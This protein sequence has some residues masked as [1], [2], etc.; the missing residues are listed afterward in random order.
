MLLKNPQVLD[1]V[2]VYIFSLF[3]SI[4]IFLLWDTIRD[5]YG[6]HMGHLFFGFSE[7]RFTTV[8]EVMGHHTG[9]LIIRFITIKTHPFRVR[10]VFSPFLFPTTV[11]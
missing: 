7:I 6:T 4:S 9:H 1:D 11:E 10:A 8:F 5:T 2:Y 3:F